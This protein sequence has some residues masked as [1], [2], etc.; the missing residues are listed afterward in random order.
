MIDNSFSVGLGDMVISP[1][2]HEKADELNKKL[3]EK[4][5]EHF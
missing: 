3:I 2:T 5:E 1:L 4:N